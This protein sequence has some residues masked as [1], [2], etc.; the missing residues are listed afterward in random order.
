MAS[1]SSSSQIETEAELLTSFL[2]DPA[3]LP[4][5][6]TLEQFR[7]LFPRE[8]RAA[9]PIRSLFLDLAAQRG[10]AVDAV[11]AAIELE[12]SRGGPAIRRA[13]A[14]QR[15][16]EVDWEVDGEVE[17]D[18]A[19]F[20][21]DSAAKKSKHTL[22]SI[23]PELDGAAGAIEAEIAK[24]RQQEADLKEAIARTIGDLGDLRT[25]K[26]TNQQLPNEVL[27]GLENLQEICSRKT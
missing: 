10:Q 25:G 14:R 26:L 5:I 16:E 24:L 13:V 17:M 7:A 21:G 20:G 11:A 22:G 3:R 1:S 23:L 18:R 12:T 4:N 15:R 2:L 9:P 19:L 6:M 8:V 27:D